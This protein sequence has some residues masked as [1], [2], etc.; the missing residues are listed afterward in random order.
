MG[1]KNF[2]KQLIELLLEK[3]KTLATAE[4]LTGGMV[5]SYLCDISGAS[6]VFPEGM[7]CYSERS[8]MLRLGVSDK[9]LKEFSA[10]SEQVAYQMAKGAREGLNTDF[11]IS[12]TGV[13]GPDD[14]DSGGNPKGLFYIGI[15]TRDEVEVFRFLERG[16][17]NE[18]RKKAAL[19]AIELLYKKVISLQQ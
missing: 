4:S 3:K 15:A 2:S 18:I 12:T 7:I 11:A 6:G 1:E 5:A 19:I 10:V 9:D 8:K 16:E 14:F 17:R 13:A